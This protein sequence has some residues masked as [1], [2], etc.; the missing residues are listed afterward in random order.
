MLL[1]APLLLL[2]QF[3]A[4][5]S[6]ASNLLCQPFDEVSL[7]VSSVVKESESLAKDKDIL[8]CYPNQ[9]CPPVC[10]GHETECTL[11]TA[12]KHRLT[13]GCMF[14]KYINKQS[15]S[16]LSS[17][18]TRKKVYKKL[19]TDGTEMLSNTNFKTHIFSTNHHL[20]TAKTGC[21]KNSHRLKRVTCFLLMSLG[22]CMC[23]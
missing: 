19:S 17:L 16:A 2:C 20:V 22:A 18:A 7:S 3:T 11:K 10:S 21:G 5:S 13:E 23:F 14:L 4:P 15:F 1:L 12:L 9:M 6:P 8:C